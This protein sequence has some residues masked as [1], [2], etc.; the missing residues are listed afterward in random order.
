VGPSRGG[1]VAVRGPSCGGRGGSRGG[2]CRSSGQRGRSARG[3]SSGLA[4]HATCSKQHRCG[5]RNSQQRRRGLLHCETNFTVSPTVNGDATERGHDDSRRYFGQPRRGKSPITTHVQY[6]G[7]GCLRLHCP[8]AATIETP[9][10]PSGRSARAPSGR[11]PRGPEGRK[12]RHRWVTR[13]PT[14][15]HQAGLVD[16]LVSCPRRT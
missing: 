3:R 12:R 13:S 11:P 8:Q 5:Q 6:A 1:D 16:H 14:R 7:P 15:R 10:V 4:V 9:R 2:R